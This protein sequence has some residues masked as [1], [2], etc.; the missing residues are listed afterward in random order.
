M[1]LS[2]GDIV[3]ACWNGEYATLK[4]IEI[5]ILHRLSKSD[6]IERPEQ[7]ENEVD[8]LEGWLLLVEYR[9]YMAEQR[10]I[11]K[12]SFLT[13]LRY[14]RSSILHGILRFLIR[15]RNCCQSW[16]SRYLDD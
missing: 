5:A 9:E 11:A 15:A 16:G 1:D 8:H 4:A 14:W 13:L 12:Y 2:F 10:L 6:C 3:Q 7:Q